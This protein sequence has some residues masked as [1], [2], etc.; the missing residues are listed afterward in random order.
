MSDNSPGSRLGAVEGW[1]AVAVLGVFWWHSWI[2]T[3]NPAFPVIFGPFRI[4]LERLFVLLGNGVDFFFVISG[5]C[6]SLSLHRAFS[7]PTASAYVQFVSNR[8]RRLSPAFYT[9]CICTAAALVIAGRSISWVDIVAHTTWLYGV[10]PGVTSLAPSFWSLQVEWEFYLCLP[11]IFFVSQ[12][13]WRWALIGGLWI[14]S[15][16]F[17]FAVHDSADGVASYGNNHLA[18]HLTPFVAGIVVAEGWRHRSDW[19]FCMG[20][21]WPFLA[22]LA[23]AYFGRG[24]ESTEVFGILGSYGS[25]AKTFGPPLMTLGF[26]AM[27]AASLVGVPLVAPALN[28]AVMQNI[29]RLSYSLYLWHW[30]PCV[31][32]GHFLRARLGVTVLS[33]YLT[34]V[35]TVVVSYPLAWLTYEFCERAYFRRRNR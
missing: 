30:W 10:W 16:V 17:R 15:L 21:M 1:R 6:I 34:L 35:A 32:F 5:F 3:G 8:W 33:H 14:A 7:R 22:G 20:G 29:G 2:H 31:W 18:M 9:V 13:R 12:A 27:L 25:F 26:A 28:G 23:V 11:L 4:D 19:L 24:M